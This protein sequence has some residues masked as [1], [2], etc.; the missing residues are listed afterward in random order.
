MSIKKKI[1]LIIGSG[2]LVYYC[3]DQLVSLG[4][5]ITIV[6][7]P[8]TEVKIEGSLDYIDL[9]YE[10]INEAFSILKRKKII[11]IALIGYIQRP[12][13]DTL[14][15]TSLSQK[16]LSRVF[17][18]FNKGDGKIFAAV[19]DMLIEQKFSPI[20]VQDLIPDLTLSSG[21][22]GD[23]FNIGK[24]FNEINVGVKVFLNYAM[25]DVGQSL[26]LQDGHCLGMETITGT[27]EMIKTLINYRNET[28]K[29]LKKLLS[30]GILIK[31]SKPDQVLDIDTPVIGPNTIK[32]AKKAK[33]DG[34]VIESNKV[35][36]V[37]KALIVDMLKS[38][39]MFLVATDF[40]NKDFNA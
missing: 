32:L 28:H 7:L 2:E 40:L 23:S 19:R 3:I 12:E 17:S 35:I 30:G 15:I 25:L 21:N 8:C 18:M 9:K 11:N 36:L 26:I 37:N 13:I 33:L 22:Y 34:L 5:E 14:K 6:R 29:K 16:I 31:G 1:G 39:N 4:Y 10:Q 27:D 38:Y 20:K 24:G